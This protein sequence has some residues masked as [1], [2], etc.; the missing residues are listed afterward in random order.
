M[1]QNLPTPQLLQT[2][3]NHRPTEVSIDGVQSRC[4]QW[5]N[6]SI[7]IYRVCE[8]P[9]NI[10]RCSHD[11]LVF[12]FWSRL[13]V[14]E[15]FICIRHTAQN[16]SRREVAGFWCGFLLSTIFAFCDYSYVFVIW[17]IVCGDHER[18]QPEGLS[19]HKK[20]TRE[21]RALPFDK[22]R[23]IIELG[24]ALHGRSIDHEHIFHVV[25]FRCVRTRESHH[26]FDFTYVLVVRMKCA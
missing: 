5:N 8:N 17:V 10:G 7:S 26:T 1:V 24:R 18:K 23:K 14:C 12:V 3:K 13:R 16:V 20:K 25:L 9:P 11:G 6:L 4:A 19:P 21:C 15:T 22:P 2:P